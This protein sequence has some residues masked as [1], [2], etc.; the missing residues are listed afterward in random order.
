MHTARM[1]SKK[2]HNVGK[3]SGQRKDTFLSQINYKKKVGEGTM[4]YKLLTK[5]LIK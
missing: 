3:S 1:Q 5:I 4:D 2:T